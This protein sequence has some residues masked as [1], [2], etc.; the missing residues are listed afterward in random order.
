MLN[1][2]S[3]RQFKDKM[4]AQQDKQQ[5]EGAQNPADKGKG[6][7]PA[8][9]ESMDEDSSDESGGE[10]QVRLSYSSSDSPSRKRLT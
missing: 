8:V 2:N 1:N 5:V 9:E 4:S 6:K 10:D 3:H 7:A